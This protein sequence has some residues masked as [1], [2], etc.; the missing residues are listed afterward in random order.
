MAQRQE[1]HGFSQG[2]LSSEMRL[3]EMPPLTLTRNFLWVFVI[4]VASL[5]IV[6]VVV[7]WAAS[8]LLR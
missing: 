4:C 3:P 8:V 6:P 5:A 7:G 2:A 1:I